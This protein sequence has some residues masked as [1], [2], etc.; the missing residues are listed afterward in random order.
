MSSKRRSCMCTSILYPKI[1]RRAFEKHQCNET[2]SFVLQASWTLYYAFRS[3]KLQT[4]FVKQP[5][6]N[7]ETHVD[8][9][10]ETM[11][12]F[13]INLYLTHHNVVFWELFDVQ[14]PSWAFQMRL[15]SIFPLN[16]KA[17]FFFL[18]WSKWNLSLKGLAWFKK[19][20]D[21]HNLT[22][23]VLLLKWIISCSK[24]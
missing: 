8:N 1:I 23:P 7:F 4:C 20:S 17:T 10:G 15:L 12:M 22:K 19:L 9:Q 16:Q 11:R 2:N 24:Q 18:P 14:D 13:L 21:S 3:R 6:S 5:F